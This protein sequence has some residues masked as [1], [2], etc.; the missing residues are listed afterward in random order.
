MV[1]VYISSLDQN[2]DI[3]EFSMALSVVTHVT[4]RYLNSS[5][6]AETHLGK[7]LPSFQKKTSSSIEKKTIFL[8]VFVFVV[9]KLNR[10]LTFY[11]I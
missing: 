3:F 1:K 9:L 8:V 2:L 11:S 6:L 5:K 10:K 7:I 4:F